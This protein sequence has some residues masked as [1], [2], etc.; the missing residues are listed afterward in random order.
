MIRSIVVGAAADGN[1]QTISTMV[2]QNQK[3]STC[4]G[5]AVRAAGVDRSLFGKEQVRAI[6]RQISVYFIGRYLMISLDTV[7]SAGIHQDSSTFDV[8]IQEYFRVLDGTV[9]VAFCCEVY[10][11]IRMFF[12]EQFV[13]SFTVCDAFFYKTE[14]RVVHNRSQS[15]QVTC[16][17]QAVQAYD[18]IIRV[19][20]QHMENKVAS[21]K[22]GTA[23]NNNI[24]NISPFGCQAP[25]KI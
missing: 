7:F 16:I 21:D 13:Y 20:F 6:Q 5:G 3:V 14:V 17:S 25:L 12:F 22:S 23:G 9:Y 8:G 1:R 10:N 24:H 18:P 15:G 2:S 4:F 11:H 19:F